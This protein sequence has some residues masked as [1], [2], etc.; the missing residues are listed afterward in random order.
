[1]GLIIVANRAPFRLTPE[2]LVPAV[3]GLATALLPV[4][5]R[6]H[7]VWVAAGEWREKGQAATPRESQVR[8]EQVFLPEK[9]W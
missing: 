6:R 8:L 9:E 4:L 2:G 5:E 1:M 7:G 3:G